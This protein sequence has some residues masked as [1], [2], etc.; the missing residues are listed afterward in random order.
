MSDEHLL[1]CVERTPATHDMTTFTFRAVEPHTF[2]FNPGQFLTIGVTIDGRTVQRCYSISSPPTRPDTLSISVKRKTGGHVSNWLH[3]NMT[4]GMTMT[5]SGP[6]G[7][8]S[9][10]GKGAERYLFISAGSGITPI[11]SMIR[12][13]TDGTTSG[14]YRSGEHT[15]IVFIH[16]ARTLEDI[17]FRTEL[18][19]LSVAHPGL[20]VAFALTRAHLDDPSATAPRRLDAATL[21]RMCPDL[22]DREVFL[23]GPG[24]FRSGVRSALIASGAS[25]AHIHEESFG[26]VLPTPT[27]DDGPGITVDFTRRARRVNVTAGS[28]ILAAAAAAGVTLPSTC[29]VGL[30]GSC[31][32]TKVSGDVVMNH[33]GGIRNREIEQG[34]ILLCCSEP[35]SPVVIDF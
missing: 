18:E 8:F 35:I 14:P 3:D 26:F 34:K 9:Y 10:M 19:Q 33:Q 32:V 29:G 24:Q 27:D 17:P 7:R 12:A 5:A 30:C 6:L 31:K 1:V 20:D 2:V 11:M 13:A 21:L 28:S 4:P 25:L 23:C 15:D 22:A 16:S